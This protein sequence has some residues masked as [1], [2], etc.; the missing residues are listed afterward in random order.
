MNDFQEQ[1]APDT[2]EFER[3]LDSFFDSYYRHRPVNATFIGVH[4]HDASLP[5]FSKTG[6]ADTLADMR[7]LLQRSAR[8][9]DF[10][11]R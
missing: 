7:A 2:P 4:D 9:E 1:G 11:D 8:Q 10:A 3:W 5:D 6:L